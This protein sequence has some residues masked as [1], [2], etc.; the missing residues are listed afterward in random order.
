MNNITTM[1]K[2][3]PQFSAIQPEHIE[4]AIKQLLDHHRRKLAKLLVQETFTW[5][6]LL[7]PLED[8]NDELS[9]MWSPVSHLYSVME[10][11]ALRAVYH[12]C[13]PLIT[14][15]HTALMQD[16]HL[17]MA[18]DSIIKSMDYKNLN[19]AQHK[20]LENEIRDFKLIGIHLVPEKKKHM[21][22]LQQQL[23]LAT[24]KF[25]DNV[26]DATG[27][28]TFHLTAAEDLAGLSESLLQAAAE[29][30]KA[31][32]M[33]GWILTLEFP[34][35]STAMKFVKNRD[36]RRQLYEAYVT[37]ASDQG[38]NA[39]RWDNTPIMSEILKIRHDI[40][41]LVG[42]HNYAELSLAT[43]MAK[44]PQEVLRFLHDL[45][46]QAKPFAKA[47]IA[48][49]AKFAQSFDGCDKLQTW[50]VAYYSEK[51]QQSKF[52][53]TQE[54]LRP[55]F[56]LERALS[57]LFT[58]VKQLY[59]L[60]IREE[61]NIDVWHPQVQFFSIYD[62]QGK[63]RG[64]LYMD[65]YARPHKRDGA[66]MDDCRSRRKLI[67]G[68]IQYPV[69]YLTCNFMRPLAGGP[70]LLTHDDVL[71]LFHE[72]GHCLHHLLTQVNYAAVSGINGVPW[73]A[74][75]FPS[76]FMEQWC[77]EKETLPLISGHYQTNEPL[78]EAL[79]NSL[80]AAKHFQAG[81]QMVRQLEF[82]LFDFRLHLEFDAKQ[83]GQ[84][85]A[86]LNDVRKETALLET[87]AFYRFPH[88]FSHIFS[89][90]YAAGYYSY[91]WAEVL[92]CDAFGQFEENGILDAKTGRAFLNTILE[93]GGVQD[94]LA[95][96]TTFRG[97][98]PKVDALLRHNGLVS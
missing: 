69:A 93:I 88:S 5:E 78:P 50:D 98:E 86:M 9:K 17:F 34:S 62:E 66:W 87:P 45:L 97:R 12:A 85:L 6:N 43:K 89:G 40:A 32:N 14:E 64:G 3:L 11:D 82:S 44:T 53:F 28:W 67:D 27:G 41:Q 47:E 22:E 65:L 79:F 90:G 1:L 10:T 61:K 29:N 7:Q 31:K 72:F 18:V 55:Y 13:L 48:E 74:V 51:L 35:Y 42:F 15:Y 83:Q 76:Q 38:P 75:E 57:G 71:T 70:A 21:A 16:E 80:L 30:A 56:P 8:M 52:N 96:F 4:P 73:D 36:I 33:A 37:R 84:V 68:H 91:K 58:I 94:P 54:E 26:L 77:W 60:E 39:N 59:G 23:S 24:T 46:A 19:A 81:M 63:L 92:S 20:V 49:L 2:E 25:S 95:A